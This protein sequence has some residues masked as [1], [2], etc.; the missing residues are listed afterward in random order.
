MKI[1]KLKLYIVEFAFLATLLYGLL[2][3]RFNFRILALVFMFFGI[4]TFILIKRNKSVAVHSKQVTLLVTIVSFTYLILFYGMGL[5]FG[6]YKSSVQLS[7]FSIRRFIIPLTIV[8]VIGEMLRHKALSQNS[9]I[10]TILITLCLITTDLLFY[11]RRYDINS[12]DGALTLIAVNLFS[13]ISRNLL[14]NYVSKR[15]GS[16]PNIIYRY[17]TV[18]YIY[19][20]PI[21]PDIHAF[22]VALINIILPYIVYLLLSFGFTKQTKVVSSRSKRGMVI[23]YTAVFATIAII[24]MV[25]SNLFTVRLLVV[26][27]GS[28]T[29]TVNKGDA[30]IY[31]AYERDDTIKV[32]NIIIFNKNNTELIHRVV[33]IEKVNGEFHYITKGDANQNPDEGYVLSSQIEGIYKGKIPYI[34]Y[35]T[36]W[37]RDIFNPR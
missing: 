16:I 36:L 20:I 22:F 15:Y 17:I 11:A 2:V 18:M 4:I 19:F 31:N 30:I 7:L 5:Y 3:K 9:K 28:M 23:G 25:V 1:D 27:S 26:G 24:A 33:E 8:I 29:G 21:T 35:L 32:G 10:A 37:P 34:G 14:C 13:S 6:F 12:Y